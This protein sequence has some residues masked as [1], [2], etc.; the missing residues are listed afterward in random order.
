MEEEIFNQE[1]NDV[2]NR[3]SDLGVP[4]G[5]SDKFLVKFIALDN[6]A[7]NEDKTIFGNIGDIVSSG[8]IFFEKYCINNKD[9]FSPKVDAYDFIQTN[10]LGKP[11]PY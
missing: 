8:P 10:S 9:C 6:L 5:V 2:C 11:S 4:M 3:L 1:V 7:K